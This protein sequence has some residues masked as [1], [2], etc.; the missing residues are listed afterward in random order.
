MFAWY[1]FVGRSIFFFLLKSMVALIRIPFC[2]APRTLPK[3]G[4]IW[5]SFISSPAIL[6]R[7]Q[8]DLWESIVVL[9]SLGKLHMPFRFMFWLSQSLLSLFRETAEV[10]VTKMKH[11]VTNLTSVLQFSKCYRTPFKLILKIYVKKLICVYP[12]LFKIFE[13]EKCS[14]G[15]V[16]KEYLYLGVWKLFM[17]CFL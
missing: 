10:P 4:R 6:K 11:T 5:P 17:P 16:L 13:L 15:S 3:R 1:Y 7:I 14:S 12:I 2:W 8:N 9:I